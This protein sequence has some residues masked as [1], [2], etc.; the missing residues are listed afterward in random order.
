MTQGE[1]SRKI[2]SLFGFNQQ[3]AGQKWLWF[4]LFPSVITNSQIILPLMISRWSLQPFLRELLPEMLF[5]HFYI[6]I[7]HYKLK[8][9]KR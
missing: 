1:D 4:C 2:N 6:V 9:P 5:L 3:I 8:S 7:Q